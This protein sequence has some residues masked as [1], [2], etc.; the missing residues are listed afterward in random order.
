MT[1]DRCTDVQDLTRTRRRDGGAF[2][3]AEPR[4]LRVKQPALVADRRHDLRLLDRQS[5]HVPLLLDH[6]GEITHVV[7]DEDEL[8]RAVELRLFLEE[9]RLGTVLLE[10]GCRVLLG[11]GLRHLGRENI[12]GHHGDLVPDDLL[13][14][15][16][17]RSGRA[18]L[19]AKVDDL[20]LIAGHHDGGLSVDLQRQTVDILQVA[21]PLGPDRSQVLLRVGLLAFEGDEGGAVHSWIDDVG[22]DRL[23]LEDIGRPRRHGLDLAGDGR[24]EQHDGRIDHG[25]VGLI[26]HKRWQCRGQDQ[27]RE[28]GRYREG[29]ATLQRSQSPA[30][31]RLP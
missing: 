4:L 10:L 20:L 3:A 7:A 31:N 12:A 13:L 9:F 6:R 28:R 8:A 2:E 1:A 18:D 24:R 22:H 16:G 23:G 5:L 11:G 19:G 25:A 30:C 29:D 27:G 26:C 14:L 17:G 15:L 21:A